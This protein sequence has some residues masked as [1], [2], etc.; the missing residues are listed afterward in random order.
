LFADGWAHAHLH[1]ETFFTPWHAILYSGLLANAAFWT[2]KLIR[3][4]RQGRDWRAAAPAGYG[5]ALLGVLL[6][7]LSGLADMTWHLI[8]GIEASVSAA[9]SPPHLGIMIG[10]GLIVSGPFIAV[11]KRAATPAEWS[12]WLPIL[13]SLAL[14]L[15]LVTFITQYSNPL[16]VTLA[17]RRPLRETHEALGAVGILLHAMILMGGILIAITRWRVPPGSLTLVLTVNVVGMSLMRSHFFLIPAIVLAAVG[18]DLLLWKLR[19]APSRPPQFHLFAFLVPVLYFYV[20]FAAVG[21]V[22]GITWPIPLWTGSALMA[23]IFSAL[24]SYL[25]LPAPYPTSSAPRAPTS[26]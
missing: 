11:W 7:G 1:V 24:L 21:I 13:L 18:A 6:S 14:T 19:P 4:R 16:V 25:I 17:S 5:L 2:W 23:G 22:Q 20:Y 15:S 26:A 8:F 3:A 10:T 9:F 12:E